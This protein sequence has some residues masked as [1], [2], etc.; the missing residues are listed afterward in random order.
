MLWELSLIKNINI[1]KVSHTADTS[2]FSPQM[3]LYFKYSSSANNPY[4]GMLS[5]SNINSIN[6]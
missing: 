2:L 3:A 5:Y 4:W 6:Y 1:F